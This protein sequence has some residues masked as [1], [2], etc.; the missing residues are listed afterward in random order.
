MGD[1]LEVGDR[2]FVRRY[3]TWGDEPSTEKSASWLGRNGLVVI[4]TRASLHRLADEL[5][6][7]I[8]GLSRLPVRPPW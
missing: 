3:S 8:K 6:V 7:E 4:D 5:L 2:V 1:W